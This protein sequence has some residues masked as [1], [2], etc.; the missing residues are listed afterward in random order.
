MSYDTAMTTTETDREFVEVDGVLYQRVD[1]TS[2]SECPKCHGELMYDRKEG[3]TT[4]VGCLKCDEW[5][6][7]PRAGG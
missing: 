1:F 4:R 7:K 2:L 5:F 3:F 6:N